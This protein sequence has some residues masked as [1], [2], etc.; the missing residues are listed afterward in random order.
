M[1]FCASPQHALG[2]KQELLAGPL[3]SSP[4]PGPGGRSG[5]RARG[6][7]EALWGN[8]T[9][10]S[11]AEGWEVREGGAG[12]DAE[13]WGVGEWGCL[14]SRAAASCL[15]TPWQGPGRDGCVARRHASREFA[16]CEESGQAGRRSL[17]KEASARGAR[18]AKGT[19]G[20]VQAAICCHLWGPRKVGKGS[21]PHSWPLAHPREL[22]LRWKAVQLLKE[23]GK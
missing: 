8:H 6:S 5:D 1:G 7:H 23:P 20:T 19:R 4:L 18:G 9:A 22:S 12:A 10:P 3:L 15:Q 16:G 13:S 2:L 21:S 17:N 11:L 14:A